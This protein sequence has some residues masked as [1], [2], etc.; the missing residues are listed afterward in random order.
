MRAG[1]GRSL[2]ARA[3]LRAPAW[4]PWAFR[5]LASWLDPETAHEL[6][7]RALLAVAATPGAR[8]AMAQRNR[9]DP[10]LTHTLWGRT[11]NSPVG[12]AAGFDKN[13]LAID[14]LAAFGFGA[15]EIGTITGQ[16]Q[17]GNPRPRLYRLPADH[18]LL[19]R[20]G[21]NNDGSA[22][23]AARLAARASARPSV[24]TR[25][26]P[27][28]D[29][30]LG[31][32]VGKTKTTPTDEAAADY[33][34]SARRLQGYADYLVVNVSS[35]NTPGLRDLQAVDQLELILRAVQSSVGADGRSAPL[36]VK[37]A[38]DLPEDDICAIADLALR[39]DLAG[40]IATNTTVSREGLVT[41]HDQL[42]A[43]GPGGV[44]GRPLAARSLRVLRL[45]R[46]VVGDRLILISAGG[47]GAAADVWDRMRCGAS[48]V[49]AYTALIYGG[50][51]WPAR[52]NRDL[53]RLAHDEG[54]SNITEIIGSAP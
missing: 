6:T 10:V 40:L 29:P 38:P 12:L 4:Y 36:L 1:S 43:M 15:V 34:L 45:L 39:L 13:G 53:A 41:A 42:A 18:A 46:S 8:T 21:F 2:Q 24:P 50:P 52:V 33:A 5:H 20:M 22:A 54:L 28:S 51:G 16:A 9:P 32:N 19:N 44:S 35:P 31:I 26:H 7:M 48:A 17:P 27:P 30:L 37:I 25:P 23:V 11:V 14:A 47:V 3:R 49:Q